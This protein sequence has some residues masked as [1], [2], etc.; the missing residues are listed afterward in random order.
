METAQ[1]TTSKE[2]A[3]AIKDHAKKNGMKIYAL[4]HKILLEWLKRGEK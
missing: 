3:Q 2:T 4:V 1:I